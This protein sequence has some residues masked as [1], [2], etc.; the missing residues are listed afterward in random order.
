VTVVRPPAW[1]T[2]S[3]VLARRSVSLGVSKTTLLSNT[4]RRDTGETGDAQQ[5][6]RGPHV[7]HRQLDFGFVGLWSC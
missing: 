2:R 6:P 3:S 7:G 5:L 4:L 1:R